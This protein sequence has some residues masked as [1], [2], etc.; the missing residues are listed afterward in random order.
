MNM[1]N[2]IKIGF[3][4]TSEY[5]VMTLEKLK[6]S[7]YDISFVVTMPDRPSGRKML[8]TPPPAKVWAEVNN[9]SIHQ[10]EKLKDQSFIEE[11]KSYN[12]DV[13]VVIAY[14]KIIPNEI[15]NIPKAKSLNIHA[16]LL[17]KFRGSCPIE[18]AI[19]ND[20][21]NTGITIMRMDNE[22]DHGPIVIQREV[23]VE[24]W[25]PTADT[26][27]KEL[28]MVGSDLLVSTLPDWVEGK[29][30]EIEQDHSQATYTKMIE[31]NDG[32]IDL[33]DDFY[34]NYLKIQ[35]Y[36][37]WPSAFFFIEK[38][39]IKIRIKIIKASFKNNELI[40]EK[41]IP[42]GKKEINYSDLFK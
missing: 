16:S 28:V 22:M 39:G 3:F 7:G 31:K 25:P 40:I 35:A 6:N 12:A 17:P 38:N 5:S 29:L 14:G 37:G 24:P 9:I 42:E 18:T 15:L 33:K 32:L 36:Q 30:K 23:I 19:L 2:K 10:P 41:V 21:K 1:N 26:L 13:F 27:G 11:L 34:K 8:L 20:E 4:G